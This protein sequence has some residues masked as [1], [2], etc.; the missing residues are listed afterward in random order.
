LITDRRKREHYPDKTLCCDIYDL[1]FLV[2]KRCKGLFDLIEEQILAED[3]KGIAISPY[4]P[5]HHN[6]DLEPSI[7]SM[8][9]LTTTTTTI[10]TNCDDSDQNDQRQLQKALA[11]SKVESL[12]ILNQKKRYKPRK[13]KVKK[14]KRKRI[15]DDDDDE[16]DEDDEE[17]EI[18]ARGHI[19]RRAE[20]IDEEFLMVLRE[21]AAEYERQ[22]QQQQRQDMVQGPALNKHPSSDILQ[23][24]I[25]QQQLKQQLFKHQQLPTQLPAQPKSIPQLDQ[26][27]LFPINKHSFVPV[28]TLNPTRTPQVLQRG[29]MAPLPVP[30]PVFMPGV[31]SSVPANLVGMI[32]HLMGMGFSQDEARGALQASQNNLAVAVNYLLGEEDEDE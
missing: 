26:K 20:D 12:N 2:D 27:S 15:D 4:I 7:S 29:T 9:T 22:Q 10:T 31:S 18:I 14:L 23:Q 19:G 25:Q 30:A 13:K 28:Q 21:S 16:D 17:E 8:S 3:T 1:T 6:P 32:D 24:Q 11:Q 5:T